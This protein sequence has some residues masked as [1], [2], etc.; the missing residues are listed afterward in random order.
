MDRKRKII[1]ALADLKQEIAGVIPVDLI[2]LWQKS[3]RNAAAERS[4]LRLHEKVGFMVNTDSAGLSKLTAQKS[5]LEV[6]RI[7]SQPKEI[8]YGIGRQ[9][10]GR[11]IGVWAADNTQ[12]FYQDI[13]I[14][15]LLEAMIAAQKQVSLGPLKV[16][17]GIHHG[18]Y[19]EIGQGMFGV[20][21]ELIDEVAEEHTAGG[22]IVLSDKC[23]DDSSLQKWQTSL[24]KRGDLDE[25]FQKDFWS[26]NYEKFSGK[27]F[28]VD[29]N[30]EDLIYPL[31]FDRK[32]YQALRQME[33]SADARNVLE[34]FFA[35]K[36]VVLV[37]IYHNKAN[38]LLDQ[39]TDW[40]VM[41]AF[42]AEIAERYAVETIKSNGDLGIFVADS[43]SE[44]VQF[45]EDVLLSM[46]RSEDRVSIGLAR[47]D[48]LL[49]NLE[50]G[51]KD[52]AGGAV[53]I[54]SK[55]S[56]DVPGH[57]TLYV[58]ESVQIPEVQR[59]KFEAFAMDKSGVVIRGNKYNVL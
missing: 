20:D 7:V 58:E 52:L 38:F 39:L 44:A 18:V 37:K 51:G 3:L 40:V 15:E 12:M 50:G 41:N 42:T 13:G 26:F 19:W 17:M 34:E 6:M 4:I 35:N 10:G 27:E 29:L 54:A 14:D 1:A 43:D 57:N 2:S 9:I 48:I 47:G 45:A 46:V 8:I 23:F 32:F 55:I 31:P 11:G 59:N 56:E 30:A 25:H 49:F 16:G 36:V 53:N 5:L 33:K 28:E 24:F 21:A 22:E